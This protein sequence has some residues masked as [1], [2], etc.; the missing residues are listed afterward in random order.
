MDS[1]APLEPHGYV[2][3]LGPNNLFKKNAVFWGVAPWHLVNR[4]FL[5][6]GS[7][8]KASKARVFNS[9]SFKYK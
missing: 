3:L 9:D 5:H 4:E 7:N 1:P 2:S 8:L 6:L